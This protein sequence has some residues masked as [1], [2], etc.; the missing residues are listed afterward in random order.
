V[1]TPGHANEVAMHI[2]AVVG[3]L[4]LALGLTWTACEGGSGERP[5]SDC[6]CGAGEVYRGG[7]SGGGSCVPTLMLGCGASCTSDDDCDEGLR[8][9]PCAASTRC[10]TR[11]C[12]PACAVASGMEPP[13]PEPLRLQTP[14]IESV[15]ETIAIEGTHFHVS[16]HHHRFR[17]GS[18]SL[19]L[20]PFPENAGCAQRVVVPS[21][22]EDGVH[23]AWASQ[24][25]G[26]PPWVLAGFLHVGGDP[27]TC[28]QPGLKCD[29]EGE[30]CCATEE[31]PVACVD[32]RC[33]RSNAE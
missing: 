32:G 29:A 33:R 2:P 28:V 12:R 24:V 7:G 19:S 22:V 17:L 23:V 1:L 8:C 13:T 31:V 11:D 27:P 16:I 26:E 21:S 25:T 14:W 3:S 5:P 20:G 10:D 18:R 4:L 15:P 30:P 6:A 9:N